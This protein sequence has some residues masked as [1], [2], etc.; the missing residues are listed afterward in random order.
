MRK[1]MGRLWILGLFLVGFGAPASA[2]PLVIA[3]DIT[4]VQL[5][6]ADITRDLQTPKQIIPTSASTHDYALKPSDARAVLGADLV[7][8]L[9]PDATPGLA[10]LLAEHNGDSV[11][12][13]N[14]SGIHRL[15]LR[16]AG[17]FSDQNASSVLDPHLWLDPEN[18]RI[19]VAGI[20]QKLSAAD[21]ENAGQYQENADT[22]MARITSVEAELQAALSPHEAAPFVQFHDA[23]QYFESAFGLNALGTATAEDEEDTSLGVIADLRASLAAHPGACLF[24]RDAAQGKRASALT[25]NTNAKLGQL[26]AIGRSI[27]DGGYPELLASV[28]QGYLACF[29]QKD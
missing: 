23:F 11:D 15:T 4:P 24:V 3:T 20:V 1:H 27:G 26:E 5:L 21:P 19:W 17:L 13:S 6:V 14:V 8:W 9:G 25:E 18:A 29:S 12:L 22:L 10:K 2:K 28:G 16:K 7:F